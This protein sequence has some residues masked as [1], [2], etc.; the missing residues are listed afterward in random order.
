MADAATVSIPQTIT[1]NLSRCTA[2]I[3]SLVVKVEKC[4]LSYIWELHPNPVV[5]P[6]SRVLDVVVKVNITEKTYMYVGDSSF[7][8][9]LF[10]FVTGTRDSTDPDVGY[11][12]FSLANDAFANNPLI[13]NGQYN[14]LKGGL[15]IKCDL[16]NEHVTFISAFHLLAGCKK[17]RYFQ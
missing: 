13:P 3:S 10:H 15:K 1:V 11:S 17:Y 9:I 14:I 7:P 8:V 6:S 4:C 16:M 2:D 12:T 5:L